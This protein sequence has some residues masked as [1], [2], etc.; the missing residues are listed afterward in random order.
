MKTLR[1]NE[2][3]LVS[4]IFNAAGLNMPDSL[5]VRAID[6]ESNGGLLFQ[7]G[8]SISQLEVA[9]LYFIDEDGE[10]VTAI[11]NSTS[12]GK[13]A[14][15]EFKKNNASRILRWP[16]KSEIMDTS[17]NKSPNAGTPQSSAP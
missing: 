16:N 1:E 15:L 11:L 14:E 5:K 13:P 10:I 3:P 17:P 8:S 2:K 6:E 12:E 9:K 7:P 4:A